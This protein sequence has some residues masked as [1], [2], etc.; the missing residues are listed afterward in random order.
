MAK[1]SYQRSVIVISG[2]RNGIWRKAWRIMAS[3]KKKG[4]S[5]VAAAA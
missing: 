2:I 3:K 1:A 4:G 5:I